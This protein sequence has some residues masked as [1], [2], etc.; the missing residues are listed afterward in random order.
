MSFLTAWG[1]KLSLALL[2]LAQRLHSLPPWWHQ[3]EEAV[4]R[5]L[6]ITCDA[7]IFTGEAG[8]VNVVKREEGGTNDLFCAQSML[9]ALAAG[10]GADAETQPD[11]ADQDALDG[12]SANGAHGALAPLSLLGQRC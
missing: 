1:M 2:V 8:G 4:R 12:A 11:A 6:G 10:R 5:V 7:E 3:T 9:R